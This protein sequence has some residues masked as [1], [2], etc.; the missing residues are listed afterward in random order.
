MSDLEFVFSSIV[1]AQ[2]FGTSYVADDPQMQTL[3]GCA[4]FLR[5]ED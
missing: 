4:Q 2:S 3:K 5:A 1:D